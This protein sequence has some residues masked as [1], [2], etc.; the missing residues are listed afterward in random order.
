M[1]SLNDG[2]IK[3]GMDNLVI[4]FKIEEKERGGGGGIVEG[5]RSKKGENDPTNKGWE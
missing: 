5:W 3:R 2:E 4:E 1:K